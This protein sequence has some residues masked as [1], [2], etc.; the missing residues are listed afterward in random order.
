M[1]GIGI[2]GSGVAGL[3]LGLFLLQHDVPVT[4]YTETTAA[5]VATGRLLNTVG[6]HHATLDRERLLGIHF[7]D[8]AEYGYDCHHHYFG[9][10]QPLYF[11]GDFASRSLSIDYRI[12]LPRLMDEYE[13]RGG[14]S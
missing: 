13:A 1:A 12:Y 10:P 9:G 2:V 6:H 7:W 11:Q 8:A 4:I 14:S 3:H 5:E